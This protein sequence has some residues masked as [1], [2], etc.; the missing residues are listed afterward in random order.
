MIHATWTALSV[1]LLSGS[2]E[3]E[4]ILL[5]WNDQAAVL[6]VY[7]QIATLSMRPRALTVRWDRRV[8]RRVV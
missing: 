2:H 8:M 6:V 4:D 3:W 1:P 5:G 7:G